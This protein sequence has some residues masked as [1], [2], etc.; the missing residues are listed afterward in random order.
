M[1]TFKALQTKNAFMKAE[2]LLF[3]TKGEEKLNGGMGAL[4]GGKSQF[5]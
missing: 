4:Q 5:F 2:L 1:V 3:P